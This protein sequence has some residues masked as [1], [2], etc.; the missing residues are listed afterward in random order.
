MIDAEFLHFLKFCVFA[1]FV[2]VWLGPIVVMNVD[3]WFTGSTSWNRAAVYAWTLVFTLIFVV[4]D[5]WIN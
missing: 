3:T 2:V 4:L 5:S 1:A